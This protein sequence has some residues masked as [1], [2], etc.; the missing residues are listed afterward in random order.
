MWNECTYLCLSWSICLWGFMEFLLVLLVINQ[1]A[2]YPC[3]QVYNLPSRPDPS[4][5]CPGEPS[6]VM[7]KG[8]AS[9]A[10]GPQLADTTK[11]NM[12]WTAGKPGPHLNIRT[13]FPRCGD[14]NV[15]DKTVERPS[16]LSHGDPYNGKTTSLYWEGP[17]LYKEQIVLLCHTIHQGSGFLSSATIGADRY[18]RRWLHPAGWPSVRLSV[19]L[20]VCLSR[21]TNTKHSSTSKGFQLLA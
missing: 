17:G 8:P 10:H 19:R 16:Y 12:E 18:C 15:K 9:G 1:L 5:V 7:A 13:V 2:H 4:E 11:H 6:I 3:E 21:T 20:S 14:S